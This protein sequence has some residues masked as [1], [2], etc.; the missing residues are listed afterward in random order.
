[1]DIMYANEDFEVET[2]L[3]SFKMTDVFSGVNLKC[4]VKQWIS[5]GKKDML[6]HKAVCYCGLL[7]F[8]FVGDLFIYFEQFNSNFGSPFAYVAYVGFLKVSLVSCTLSLSV[9]IFFGT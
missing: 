7:L 6:F 8:G 4:K 1:M 9:F 5:S 3:I 2:V